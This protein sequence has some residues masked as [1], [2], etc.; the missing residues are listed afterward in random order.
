MNYDQF[1]A[2]KTQGG[3]DSGF[4]PVWMPDFLFDFQ[5]SIVDWAVRKGRAAI[6]ADCGLGKTPMVLVWASKVARKMSLPVLYLTPMAVG[7]Q[8]IREADKFGIEATHSRD[9]KLSK[10]II[11]TNYE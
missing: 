2:A 8:T 7:P 6:F 3:A 11:V 10:H 9:G 4:D 5:S 1:I